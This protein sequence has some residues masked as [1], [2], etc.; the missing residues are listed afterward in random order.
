M[1]DYSAVEIW[2]LE[3]GFHFFYLTIPPEHQDVGIF[4]YPISSALPNLLWTLEHPYSERTLPEIIVPSLKDQKLVL[5]VLN[6]ILIYDVQY[7]FRCST[8]SLNSSDKTA[9]S[10]YT[11]RN[12]TIEL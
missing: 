1:S 5:I 8:L 6:N 7:F 2:I 12:I 10:Q 3:T 11:D 9:L 4:R